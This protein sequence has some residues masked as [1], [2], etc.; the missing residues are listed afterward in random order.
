MTRRRILLSV[1]WA[2]ALIGSAITVLAEVSESRTLSESLEFPSAA[3]RL[4][5]DNV[6]GSIVVGAH[7]AGTI[8]MVT[9]ETIHARSQEKLARAKSEVRLEIYRDDGEIEFFVDGPF[10]DENNR[11]EWSP[12][13]RKPGYQVVYDF[14]IRVPFD[15]ELRL[16]T[17]NDGDI[18]VVD[19]RGD[20][21]VHNVNGSIRLEGMAGSGEAETVNGPVAATFVSNPATDTR[22]ATI[23]GEI[24]V[25]FQPGLSAD[26]EMD[27]R[28]GELWIEYE[29][30]A[31]PQ[32]PPVK[33]T[34][35]DRTVIELG[36]GA[37][38]RVGS[39]GPT[40][41]FETLNGDIYVRKGTN[42]EG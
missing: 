38:V 16:R 42:Q 13:H 27:A 4:V 28:W 30:T 39:G 20:F 22:F 1:L 34:R 36:G 37:R 9:Q 6:H 12:I 2:T 35:G 24:D 29:V 32:S 19:V 10:R 21:Q 7:S 25:E 41:S 26:L 17:V 15:T 14:E 40:H 31:L 5:V 8:E 11:H 3:H 23:N 18:E 33:K